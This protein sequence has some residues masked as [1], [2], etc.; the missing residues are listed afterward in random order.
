MPNWMDVAQ[1]SA[2]EWQI[3]ELGDGQVAGLPDATNIGAFYQGIA[4]RLE[5]KE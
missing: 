4:Q 2:G 1:S 3:I 5:A